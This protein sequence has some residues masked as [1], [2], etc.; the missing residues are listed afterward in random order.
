MKYLDTIEKISLYIEKL[1]SGINLTTTLITQFEINCKNE[2]MLD[3]LKANLFLLNKFKDL[4]GMNVYGFENTKLYSDIHKD[5]SVKIIL[6]EDLYDKFVIDYF[7]NLINILSES[8]VKNCL[9]KETSSGI[10]N[11]SF[12]W[13]IQCKQE[14]IKY[15]RQLIK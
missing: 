5:G 7:E 15:Y 13:Q 2:N 8:L 9:Y 12:Q 3:Y 1:E 4:I 11:I 10:Y 6:T 14:I